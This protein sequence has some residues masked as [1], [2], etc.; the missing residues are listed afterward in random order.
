MA[1]LIKV[2]EVNATERNLSFDFFLWQYS[3]EKRGMLLRD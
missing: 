1:E 3:F 2:V